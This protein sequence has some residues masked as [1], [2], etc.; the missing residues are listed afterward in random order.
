MRVFS[1]IFWTSLSSITVTSAVAQGAL[2]ARTSHLSTRPKIAM[3]D[4]RFQSYNVEMVE[5]TGGQ[6]WAPYGGPAEEM[7]RMRP[8][9]DLSDWRL[10]ALP[11]HLGP[12]YM[13]V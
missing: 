6:F 11:R 12:S 9:E 2:D 8:P 10:R 5:V 13:R 7:Y 1:L 3:I 4:E